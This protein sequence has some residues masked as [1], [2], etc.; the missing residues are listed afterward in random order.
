LRPKRANGEGSISRRPNGTWAAAASLPNGRRK[1]FYGKTREDVRRKLSRA[2]HAI[3]VGTLADSKGIT[4]A[5]FLDQWLTEVVQPN[6]RPWTYKG[7]EVHVRLHLKPSIGHIPL[8]KLT[9][10]HVQQLLN[11]KK[12]EGLSAK[13]IRYIRGTLRT[14]L[15]QAVRWELLTRNPAGL[16]D[17]PRV[18]HYEIHPFTPD[19]ARTFL[20]ALKGDRLEALYS[21]ALTMGL[22]QGEALG[23]CWKE[24]DLEMGYLRV[25]QQLQRFDGKTRLV[26][27]KTPRSRRTLA[28]PASIVRALKEHRDRQQSEREAAGDKWTE[29]GLVFTTPNGKPIDATRVSKDF[30]RHL[31]RAGLSQRRFHDLR[32]SC[33]TLLL[34]QGVSPRVVMEV[35]GHSQISL[36]M[37]TYTHVLPELRRQAADRM[38]EL[39]NRSPER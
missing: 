30:H 27:P 1:F 33:A 8:D 9:P 20:A 34:V 32:H 2:L 13:S 35:L 14:A 25:S 16:V 5:E 7:Y 10:L 19:E 22:R 31:D 17:G 15:N 28:L 36:T 3:D 11:A 21:V 24:V 18:E 37:N 23:L 39:L 12:S 29:T 38:D 6:V 26:E 4:V